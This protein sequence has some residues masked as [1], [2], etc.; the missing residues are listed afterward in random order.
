MYDQERK[1]ANV[2]ISKISAHGLS[3][4][5]QSK[6][7]GG[8][9]QIQFAGLS[10]CANPASS[11]PT[12]V[13][14]LNLSATKARLL[15]GGTPF[16]L[17]ATVTPTTNAVSWTSSNSA[18]A[19]VSS[20][21]VVT[22][23]SVGSATITATS[24]SISATCDITGNVLFITGSIITSSGNQ[25][26]VYWR[27]GVQTILTT[28]P[29][30]PNG[31]TCGLS[32]SGNDIIVCGYKA[33]ADW[34]SVTPVYWQNGN[35]HALAIPTGYYSTG[36][37][38]IDQ[39]T[40]AAGNSYIRGTLVS[41]AN[42]NN[43][44]GYW[45]NGTWTPLSMTLAPGVTASSGDINT[46]YWDSTTKY[47]GGWLV[48]PTTNKQVPVY[49]ANGVVSVVSLGTGQIASDAATYNGAFISSIVGPPDL[50]S[51]TFFLSAN[52]SNYRPMDP[53]MLTNGMYTPV[54]TGGT[55]N[56]VIWFASTLKNGTIIAQGGIGS[57]VNFYNAAP[58][59]W[60]NWQVIQL[61][62]PN[63][64]P[65]GNAG[66]WQ[67]TDSADLVFTGNIGSTTTEQLPV[68]WLNN[69][70]VSLP[71]GSYNGISNISGEAKNCTLV[72]Y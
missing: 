22:V 70:I 61:T 1:I 35:S 8:Q 32:T 53:T 58:M 3:G 44:P 67:Y 16:Q 59:Y 56:G 68:Y 41:R 36:G 4:L 7:S 12:S 50:P 9:C 29:D 19:T 2:Y 6:Q 42:H 72:N 45:L 24:G 49:W 11:S 13:T 64:Y 46:T 37:E 66:S 21:G 27:N 30:Q 55:S 20:S 31:T 26:P 14:T 33:N 71:L 62:T 5:A 40:D 69:S 47:W 38:W 48:D 43:I 60:K 34:S 15:I 25:V 18:V 51:V 52:D 28:T 17:S 65:F 39:S 57:S 23:L 10:A 63:G 54:S